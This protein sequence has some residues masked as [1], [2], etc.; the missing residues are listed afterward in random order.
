MTTTL[1][2]LRAALREEYIPPFVCVYPP[3]SAY[4]PTE[5]PES[6]GD[7]WESDLVRSGTDLN[8]YVHVPFCA[9]KC[10]FCNL[11]TTI[12]TQDEQ[13]ARYVSALSRQ[14][15]LQRAVLE[16]RHVRTLYIGGGTPTLLRPDHLGVIFDTLDDLRSTWRLEVREIAIEASPD[17]LS[18]PSGESYVKALAAL[19]INR[20]NIGVQSLQPRE[21]R[22]AGRARAGVDKIRD[23]ITAVRA[24][25]IANLSTDLI[26]GFHGQTD[27]TWAA[28]V[29]GL[30]EY[31]PDTISTYF[32]TI[33]PDAWFIRTGRYEYERDRTLYVRYDF[34]RDVLE[35]SGYVQESN[36][37]YVLPGRGGYL[38][39]S[40]QFAGVPV[41]GIGAGA[42]S[43]NNTVDYLVGGGTDAS[44]RQIET[45]MDQIEAGVLRATSG[46]RLSDEERLRKR[47]VLDLFD[48][49]LPDLDKFGRLAFRHMY[50]PILS[51]AGEL[52]LIEQVE[53]ERYRLT[54]LGYRHRDLLS[55]AFFSDSIRERD[56]TFY[57]T[58]HRKAV[59]GSRTWSHR[60][61]ADNLS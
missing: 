20:I 34:A 51:C 17:S 4:L 5:V 24:A 36:V 45:Y 56:T 46:F 43:Y 57:H 16:A 22:D 1:E 41:L 2:N 59:D 38:Q 48:L 53:P 40:L 7:V 55:W 35:S 12:C 37:R 27:E 8:I 50:E 11:Y 33:R 26:I 42:R 52:G 32:L 49:R 6:L 13:H 25:G 3:R 61:I 28:S 60:N 58:L 29:R 21:L 9:Y 18:G 44:M 54:P 19:G 39:K 10:G 30:V 47:L 15:R 14:L 23:A 31:R